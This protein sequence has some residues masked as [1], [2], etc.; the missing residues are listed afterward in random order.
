MGFK[1]VDLVD[2]DTMDKLEESYEKLNEVAHS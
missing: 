1:L 2:P